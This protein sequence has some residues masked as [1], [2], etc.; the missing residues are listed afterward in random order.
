MVG[1]EGEGIGGDCFFGGEWRPG[2]AALR[3]F[4]LIASLFVLLFA[5]PPVPPA[6]IEFTV[7][8]R[9]VEPS[10]PAMSPDGRWKVTR[11]EPLRL[12]LQGK[13][14]DG[15][16]IERTFEMRARRPNSEIITWNFSDD[17]SQIAIG[18]GDEIGRSRGD[19]AG[20]V[21]VYDVES[22]KLIASVSDSQRAIGYV[23]R[24]SFEEKGKRV[25]IE[26]EDISG[27]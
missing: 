18:T 4:M 16:P 8:H 24:V 26:C 27:K 17:C 2:M 13:A 23:Y 7:L 20:E 9:R 25:V 19:S 1:I 10:R 6:G 12:L 14:A 21:R 3:A 5:A 15:T 22:A 11:R